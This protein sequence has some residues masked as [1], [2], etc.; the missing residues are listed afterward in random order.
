MT[1]DEA[2]PV[3]REYGAPWELPAGRRS[4]HGQPP[5]FRGSHELHVRLNPHVAARADELT[6]TADAPSADRLSA[7]PSMPLRSG[8][9]LV[10]HPEAGVLRLAYE[11]LALPDEGRRLVVLLPADEATATALDRLS[12]RTPGD[13]RAVRG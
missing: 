5:C 11:T 12:G 4:L 8:T 7:V 2:R 13:L 10:A 3:R 6:V 9:G 1:P